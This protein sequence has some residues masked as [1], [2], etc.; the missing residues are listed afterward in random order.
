MDKDELRRNLTIL[1]L[2]NLIQDYSFALEEQELTQEEKDFINSC[3]I[4]SQ[5]Y[6]DDLMKLV[7]P[8][9]TISKPKWQTESKDS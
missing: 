4:E 6:L 3:I 9:E 8:S 7:D 5:S 2:N 1:A